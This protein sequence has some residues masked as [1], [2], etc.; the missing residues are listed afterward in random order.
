MRVTIVSAI[1]P[2]THRLG[3]T[4]YLRSITQ[5]LTDSG[6]I[7]DLLVLDILS[8]HQLRKS[9]GSID[10]YAELYRSVGLYG[11]AQMGQHIYATSPRHWLDGIHAKLTTGPLEPPRWLD[12]PS[13]ASLEWATRQ[14]TATQ[15]DLVLANYF[16]AATVFD[17]LPA[18]TG[19]AILMHDLVGAR[20]ASFQAAGA[21]P[22]FD[23]DIV[24]EERRAL[25]KADLCIA[26]KRSE[27][28]ALA[29]DVA[30]AI[31]IPMTVGSTM[32]RPSSAQ[33]VP[34]EAVA[35]FVGGGFRANTH[36]LEWL[37]RQVWPIVRRAVPQARLRVVGGVADLADIAWAEGIER[38]GFVPDLN[39]EYSSAAVCVA[40]LFI[41]SGMKVKVV[42]ALGHGVPVVATPC[43]AEGLEDVPASF[44][45]NAL[46]AQ[47]F[48][49]AL[50]ARLMSP[51]AEAEHL[52][53]T[54][55]AFKTFGRNA[56]AAQLLDALRQ[57]VAK[58]KAG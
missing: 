44:M 1:D 5:M 6:A 38:V 11:A 31:H 35:L 53:I 47:A 40:P 12:P 48:A 55:Y 41:G 9:A 30:D 36:G 37:A 57:I 56:V 33:A 27:V 52:A 13:P 43:A 20:L 46:D 14:I 19:R 58:R 15:P 4:Q 28:E 18:R 42:E 21:A 54:E 2:L 32:G 24:N 23:P 8:R 26:I 29:G 17:L 34:R 16:N 10:H 45:D 7:V 51:V 25:G 50:I 39:V 22:D 49:D 3:S